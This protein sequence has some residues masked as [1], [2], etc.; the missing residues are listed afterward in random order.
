VQTKTFDSGLG[1]TGW[2]LHRHPAVPD[3]EKSEGNLRNREIRR[4]FLPTSFSSGWNDA[5]T[6]RS[7][8]P[9]KP[10][11]FVRTAWATATKT[12]SSSWP[13]SEIS[14]HSKRTRPAKARPRPPI[15]S[16]NSRNDFRRSR[17]L[18]SK[19]FWLK[20]APSTDITPLTRESGDSKT[21]S[22]SHNQTAKKN[23]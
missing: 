12:T 13:R 4:R 1:Q 19:L 22:D 3:S 16:K 10:I 5:A 14:S 11:S 18:C 7:F 21:S 17:V 15:F 9:T 23:H 6:A 2:L 20:S 8:S